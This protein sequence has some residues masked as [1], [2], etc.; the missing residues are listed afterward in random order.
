ML[1]CRVNT[2]EF[3]EGLK[4]VEVA[5]D[6]KS[7]LPILEHVKLSVTKDQLQLIGTDLENY[8]TITIEDV[9]VE[10]E[11]E[12]VIK[13]IKDI[14]KSF[15]FMKES[16]TEIEV[17]NRNTITF[18]NGSRNIKLATGE[19]SEYPDG[20]NFGTIDNQYLYDTKTLHNRIKKIDFA[21]STDNIRPTLT[22]I[23]FNESDLVTLDGYRA[24]LSNDP[25]DRKSVV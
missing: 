24:A 12:T 14:I 23:Y 2:R 7:A 22:G 10:A 20:F 4:R 15:K 21:K 16:Y 11:G 8:M 1:K 18:T 25:S 5:T 6:R 3:Q 13:N 19:V 17:D 9:G